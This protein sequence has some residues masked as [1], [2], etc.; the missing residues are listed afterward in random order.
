MNLAPSLPKYTLE[1]LQQTYVLSIPQAVKILEEF[2]GDRR[3]IDKF[4]RRCEQRS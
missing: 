2:G 3:Q 1:Q 4:M